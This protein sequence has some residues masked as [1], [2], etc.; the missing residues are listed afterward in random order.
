MNLRSK[1]PGFI[2]MFTMMIL[3]AGVVLVGAVALRVHNAIQEH[4]FLMARERAKLAALGGIELARTRL[5]HLADK[6]K[7]EEVKLW[8]LSHNDLWQKISLPESPDNGQDKIYL[9]VTREDGKIDLNSFFDQK[10]K[11]FVFGKKDGPDPFRDSVSRWVAR[12]SPSFGEEGFFGVLQEA[13][14]ERKEPL[15]DLTEIFSFPVFEKSYIPLFPMPLGF[16]K[17][18]EA[19]GTPGLVDLFSVAPLFGTT[20]PCLSPEFLSRALCSVLELKPLPSQAGE[21]EQW[22]K[23]FLQKTSSGI[24]AWK[25]AW[26][27]LV[28]AAYDKKYQEIEKKY[29]M[30]VSS[31]CSSARES[32]VSVVS[33]GSVGGVTQGVYAVLRPY[34][35]KDKMLAYVV[36]RLYWI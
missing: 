15:V 21:R 30:I 18:N 3:A 9:R 11:T 31:F 10:K 24:G 8:L 26:D 19:E 23:E 14:K 22:A 36:T 2:L 7:E 27:Q 29:P 28:S 16:E 13:L 5:T 20:K 34:E 25:F 35:G 1:Q 33:Y 32:M 6:K 17:E 12:I 4:R